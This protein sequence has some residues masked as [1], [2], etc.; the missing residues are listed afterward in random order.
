MSYVIQSMKHH[1]TLAQRGEAAQ[2]SL[3]LTHDVDEHEGI[4]EPVKDGF[5]TRKKVDGGTEAP[6]LLKAV[7]KWESVSH[8][9]RRI[10]TQIEIKTA[11]KKKKEERRI[12]HVASQREELETSNAMR[13]DRG[14][15]KEQERKEQGEGEK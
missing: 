14:R 11:G 4:R 15:E 10:A 3:S 1:E 6:A 7:K 8:E 5:M 9:R 12:L 2:P 13:R